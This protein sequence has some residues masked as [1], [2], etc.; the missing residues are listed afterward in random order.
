MISREILSF[1][2]GLEYGGGHMKILAMESSTT[3]AKAMLYDG[4]T[5]KTEVKTKVY[6]QRYDDPTLHDPEAV[7]AD[8][9]WAAKEVLGGARKIDMI[10]LGG[11]WHSLGLFDNLMRPQTAVM[12]W[13]FTGA[14]G[15][16]QKLRKDK[17]Y[18]SRFY[19]RTGCMVNAIYPFFK[20]RML[21]QEGYN[22]QNYLIGGQGVYNTFRM[23][24]CF[25]ATRCIASGTGL[26]NIHTGEYDRELLQELGI[27]ESGLPPL[28]SSEQSYPLLKGIA[29]YLEIKEGTPVLPCNS[30]GG[31]N[32]IGTGAIKKGVMT[33]SVGT[34][35][36]LRL[37]CNSPML[38]SEPATWCYRSPKA[39]LTGAAVSGACNCIDWFME[40]LGNSFCYGDLETGFCEETDLPVFL[41]F[42]FGERCPG[43]KDDR[44]GGFENLKAQNSVKDLYRA[45]Q[46]GILFNLYQCYE[47]LTA[48]CG[49]PERLKLSGGIVN[50]AVWTQ[51]C[52][53]IFGRQL[54][55][56]VH[57]QSSLMGGIVL[58]MEQLGTISDVK[59]YEVKPAGLVRPNENHTKI[60]RKRYENY[61]K[62]YLK[63]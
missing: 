34:S 14:S 36:A 54:E 48:Q 8:M 58:A 21:R 63:M 4:V 52:A 5:K 24:G 57:P 33:F 45:V 32:Q 49:E 12:P 22:L 35:G 30:D 53:D 51:M 59:D 1:R 38:S 55:V 7:F 28:V 42:I 27:K 18:I 46:E 50:S 17:E 37:S 41:P 11:T 39:F 62:Y 6:E 23:T 26:M 40:K 47:A 29:D 20:L 25:A 15:L 43:W 44:V 3:S 9:L 19:G 2:I 16:C 10:S 56:D 13:C 31:L 60:Y 61:L